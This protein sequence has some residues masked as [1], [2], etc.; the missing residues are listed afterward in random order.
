[1]S[2]NHEENIP[3][4]S[5]SFDPALIHENCNKYSRSARGNFSGTGRSFHGR[6]GDFELTSVSEVY[7][8]EGR[9]CGFRKFH[10]PQKRKVS[11]PDVT[12]KRR[13]SGFISLSLS[14]DGRPRFSRSRLYDDE[15]LSTFSSGLKRGPTVEKGR[16]AGCAHF[17]W[18]MK[19]S[20]VDI[21]I[22]RAFA[23]FRRVIFF[24]V[25]EWTGHDVCTRVSPCRFKSRSFLNHVPVTF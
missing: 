14:L 11:W 6:S 8:R 18:Q 12:T 17:S 23:A 2:D 1:M 3:V 13:G 22:G 16:R 25:L 10:R 9:S 4:A 20:S 15:R 19:I 7:A 21:F 5:R 24:V